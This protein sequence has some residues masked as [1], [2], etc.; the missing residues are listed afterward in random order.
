[1]T[2]LI[3]GTRIAAMQVLGVPKYGVIERELLRE[4][5]K[6]QVRGRSSRSIVAERK[7]LRRGLI[8]A[9]GPGPR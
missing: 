4:L 9:A 6:E 5:T 2:N 3:I 7:E 8:R 1:V